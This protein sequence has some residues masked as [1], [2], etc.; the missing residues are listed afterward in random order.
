MT[1]DE[2]MALADLYGHARHDSYG[3]SPSTLST[4][5]ALRSAIEALQAEIEHEKNNSM[6]LRQ[7]VNDLQ[8]DK[9]RLRAALEVYARVRQGPLLWR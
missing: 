1:T 7:Q 9:V 4:R 8:A 6:C 2:I 3:R 5:E